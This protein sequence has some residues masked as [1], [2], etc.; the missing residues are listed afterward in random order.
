MPS[1]FR[2]EAGPEFR[3]VAVALREVDSSLPTWLRREMRNVV[4]PVV[5]Q[6]RARVR[7]LEVQGGPA[8]S[9]GLR[10][11][12]ASGVRVR[13]GVGRSPRLRVV[14][15]MPS[16]DLAAIPRGLDSPQGW[17]HP[18]FGNT[19]VW[20]QQLPVQG[21]WFSETFSNSQDE[22]ET[23]L[24]GVLEEARDRIAAAGGPPR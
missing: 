5:Q 20:V 9:T 23:G 11:K 12:V 16:P 2:M 13:A 21:G 14:T 1:D 19:D 10:R 8:G 4:N 22:F 18:V 17:R 15:T 7:T 3:R 6:A 24:T